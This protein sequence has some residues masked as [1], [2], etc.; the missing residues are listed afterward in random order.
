MFFFALDSRWHSV[1]VVTHMVLSVYIHTSG[2]WQIQV[3]NR[4][5]RANV[6]FS[7]DAK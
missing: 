2:Q 1:G 4:R 3:L 7:G 5:G 6:S